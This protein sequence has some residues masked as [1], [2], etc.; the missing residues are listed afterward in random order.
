MKT[1]KFKR[2]Y[3]YHCGSCG[4]RRYTRKY[5]RWTNEKC[6]LCQKITINENQL[7]LLKQMGWQ[8]GFDSNWNRDIGYGVPAVCDHPKCN[9]EIDRGLSY[10]C[11]G[12][13]YGGEYGCGLFFC[14]HH[15]YYRKP[16]GADHEVQLCPR[17]M[18]YRGAYKAKSDIREWMEW[19]MTDESWKQWRNDNPEEVKKLQNQLA[20]PTYTQIVESKVTKTPTGAIFS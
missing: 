9:E 15:L 8:I 18:A 17:C 13:P 14:H 11:G 12:D 20:L 6:T 4:K 1:V 19:K 5:S 3:T 16:R 10:V 7:T 2:I